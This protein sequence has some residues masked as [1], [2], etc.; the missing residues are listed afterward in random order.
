M[1]RNLLTRI[2]LLAAILLFGLN[3]IRFAAP[4]HA[5][6]PK[7]IP[8]SWGSLKGGSSQLLYFEDQFGTIRVYDV[9]Q[10]RLVDEIR[11]N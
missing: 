8:A 10:Q 6:Q 5:Q 11:R 4:V 2:L 1:S 7:M 9:S 3:L